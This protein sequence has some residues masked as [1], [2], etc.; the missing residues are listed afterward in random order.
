MEEKHLSELYLKEETYW[1]HVNK[2]QLVL[3]FLDNRELFSGPVLE[4][5]CGGG[6]LSFILSQSGADVVAGDI[7]LEAAHLAKAKGVSK[8]ITF[9]AGQP[10]PFKRHSFQIIIMLDVLEHIEDD[11][12]CLREVRR[13]LRSG[14]LM[15]LTVPAHQLFFSDW[16]RLLEHYRR[17][18]K[19][20]LRHILRMTGFQIKVLSYQNVLSFFPALILRGK[21][22]LL[23]IQRERAEFPVVPEI[24]NKGLT[25]WGRL[26]SA[27]I[28]VIRL[29]VGL[30]LVAILRAE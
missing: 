11:L 24:V 15:V 3:K 2:R 21:D 10:W 30:S 22:R 5:G 26:E 14:G 17:Y 13:V 16:D 25:C 28:P 8:T 27:L 9:D 7:L 18:S 4:V 20:R 12:A 1:W 29:P 23:G 6:L 19:S